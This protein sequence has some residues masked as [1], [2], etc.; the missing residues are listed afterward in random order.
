L[1]TFQAAGWRIRPGAIHNLSTTPLVRSDVDVPIL[2]IVLT[3][4]AVGAVAKYGAE[5]GLRAPHRWRTAAVAGVGVLLV[6]VVTFFLYSRRT[7]LLA[8]MGGLAVMA[9][10]L[11]LQ[12]R[13]AYL[14]PA[15]AIA[16]LFWTLLAPILVA[17]T[18]N[19]IVDSL[20]ARNDPEHYLTATFR[21]SGWQAALE[22]ISRPRL[23]HL[24]GYGGSE[25]LGIRMAHTHNVLLQLFFDAGLGHAFL[26]RS[27]AA[28]LPRM[29]EGCQ[30]AERGRRV[31]RRA[32]GAI[33]TC[34]GGG[35]ESTSAHRGLSAAAV[36]IRCE[37]VHQRRGFD[38]IRVDPLP[39]PE[40]PS[41]RS[42]PPGLPE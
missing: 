20:L 11:A 24:W 15:I 19:P 4:V 41:S 9:L 10:P 28:R 12:R 5:K 17:M 16:P 36:R 35:A 39:A 33:R 37:R 42:R 14:T 25:I 38:L 21:L 8:V 22:F 40:P 26:R 32:S 27:A 7:P 31:L 2:T 29:P 3:F 30:T 18:Q 13:M 23:Q 34:A 6:A 1:L